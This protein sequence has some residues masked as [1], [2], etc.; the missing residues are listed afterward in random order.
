MRDDQ[1]EMIQFL[2]VAYKE[3]RLALERAA[4]NLPP[5]DT[6]VRLHVEENKRIRKATDKKVARYWDQFS[7]AVIPEESR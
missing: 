4:K 5:I 6:R 2:K 1:K 3:T 7:A